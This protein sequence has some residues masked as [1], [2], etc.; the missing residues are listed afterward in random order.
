MSSQI[1]SAQNTDTTNSSSVSEKLR[2]FIDCRRCDDS[3]IRNEVIFVNFVRDKEDAQLHL[4]IT[5]QQAGSG[6]EFT[7][8]FL[9]RKTF[10]G[11]EN[12]LKFNSPSSDTEDDQRRGLVK[13]V[14]LGLFPYV[15][16]T[17]VIDN[18]E[19]TYNPDVSAPSQQEDDPWNNWIFELNGRMF[20]DGEESSNNL[21]LNGGIEAERITQEW[22]IRTNYNYDYNRREETFTETDSLGNQS[23]VTEVFITRG[24]RFD[25]SVIKSIGS[26]WAGGIFG[27]ALSSTRNNFDFVLAGG[28]GIEY[29]LF[30]YD[31]YTEREFTFSYQI[32]P[33]YRNYADTTIFNK[34]KEFLVQHQLRSRA[35]FTQ[36]WGEIEGRA[37]FSAFTQDLSKNRLDINLE[38]DF[39]IFRGLS[40][41]FSGRYSLINDQLSVPKGN[42]TDAEQL[43][44]LRERLTG[45]SYRGSI[46]IEYTFGSIFNSTVNP[47]F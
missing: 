29:N 24:Q 5:R 8:Q 11:Q 32:N 28:P 30:P 44:D 3:Y 15:S 13:K 37:N 45:Y 4:L 14:K 41:N 42:I 38:I 47:R 36:P 46:G 17:D 21:F 27:E 22:K 26:H 43:L 10:S 34:T 9:G 31:E 16:G 7:L 33:S 19:I 12:I 20:F 23:N 6:S 18:L 39:R 25:G 2:V 35:E 40:L 1:V